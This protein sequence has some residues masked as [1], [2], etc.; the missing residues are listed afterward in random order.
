MRGDFVEVAGIENEQGGW[1]GGDDRG[2]ARQ[3]VE[4]RHL[5]EEAALAELH[6]VARQADLDLAF[7]D[8]EHRI[9]RLVAA[10]HDDARRVVAHAQL[11]HDLRERDRAK[12]GE[13]RHLGHLIPDAEIFAAAFFLGEAGGEDTGHERQHQDAAHHDDRPDHLAAHRVRHDVTVTGGREGDDGPPECRWDAAE[14]IGL[15][16]ALQE[17][18]GRRRGD[19]HHEE[20]DEHAGKRCAFVG[21]HA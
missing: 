2:A 16:V 3:A 14:L 19:Q 6:G 20:D 4:Q 15:T 18:R 17:M 11:A 5:A 12:L 13:H 9:A 7:G 21:D 10:H 1:L 8:E